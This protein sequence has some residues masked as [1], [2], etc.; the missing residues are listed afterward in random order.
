LLLTSN[1]LTGLGNI[2]CSTNPLRD[3]KAT[4]HERGGLIKIKFGNCIERIFGRKFV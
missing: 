2:V 4:K 1:P 3:S